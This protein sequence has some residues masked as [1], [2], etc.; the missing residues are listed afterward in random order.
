ML[1]A[2]AVSAQPVIT[3]L[4][5][6]GVQKGRPFTLTL[7]GRNLGDG[8]KIRSSM[9]AT[10]TLL[11]PERTGSMP[12]GRPDGRMDGRY[13]TFLVEP[14]GDL[15]V[16]AYPIRVET[17]DGISN[18]QLL[19]VGAFPECLEDESRPGALAN[20]NDTIETAQPLPP[21][22]LTLNG[23]LQGPERDVFRIQ[24]KSGEK[25]V[26]EVEARRLGSAIDP[27]LEI[28]DASGKTLARSEDAPLLGL[29]ARVAVTFPREGYYYVVVHDSR[30][31]TQTAN[32]YRLKVG[33][34][35]FPQEIF[36]LGGRRGE[37][38]ETSLGVQKITVDLRK[39]DRNAGQVFVNLPDSAVLPVPFAVGDDPEMT[40]PVADAIGL[41]VTINA[42]LSK[43]GQVDRYK[44]RASPG[45]PLAFRIQARELGTSKLMAV[46]TVFDEN[47]KMLGRSG[48]EPLAE[49]VYNVNQSRT[50]GDPMLRVKA[51]EGSSNVVVTVEDLALRGGPNYAY[52]LN[53][54]SVAQDFRVILNS[55]FLNVPAGGSATL[56]VTVQRQ[57]Y[58]GEVQLRVANAPVG[59]RVEGGYVVA[60]GPVKETPQNRNS[61]GVLILTAEPGVSLM[62]ADLIVEGVGRLP[63]GASLVRRAEGPGMIVNVAGASEQG[64]VDRQRPLTAP[65]LA[66][67]LPVAQ[68]KSRAAALE[69]TMLERKR[70][71]E[72]DQIQ[73]RWKW[74]SR[75]A[76]LTLPKTVNVEM[77][78]GADVRVIDMRTSADDRITGT[79]LVTTTKLTRPS[80]YDLYVSGRVTVDGQQEDI[81]SRPI[82]VEVEEV[83][84]R[85][86]ETGSIR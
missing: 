45:E 34:Y 41:P 22:P 50:A 65:W 21:A 26:F 8:T 57:G 16:G 62:T 42:R 12:D 75:D 73:F 49:D 14:T 61:R 79:F 46:I 37:V 59:L 3:D 76:T 4:Q 86:A 77:V 82:T 7:T 10:F 23:A 27:V 48:D 60:G 84:A 56:P 2:A 58:D 54:Q 1:T 74:T 66:L 51:P 32:F 25:Q 40:A 5:P 39:V 18:I 6:R 9:P 71:E 52:R 80:K 72:G 15:A 83:K 38:V 31:S 78:G 67:D 53:V 70:M 19:A 64:S 85:N 69:V 35:A 44:V 81:V 47:G 17:P 43:P 20:S 63:E 36:P 13:A 55:P 30:Y 28:L 29:D 24:A 68:T 11:A 33:S